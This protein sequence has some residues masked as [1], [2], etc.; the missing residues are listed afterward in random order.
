MVEEGAMLVS[1]EDIAGINLNKVLQKSVKF[2]I[3]LKKWW[4]NKSRR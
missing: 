3:S 2:R 1:E 4:E